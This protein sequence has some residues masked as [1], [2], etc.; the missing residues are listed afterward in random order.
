MGIW[1]CVKSCWPY[2]KTKQE[3]RRRGV[4]QA[5]K[6]W[7]SRGILP[8]ERKTRERQRAKPKRDG[9]LATET[10]CLTLGGRP[11]SD[12]HGLA[13]LTFHLRTLYCSNNHALPYYSQCVSWL[14]RIAFHATQWSPP[15]TMMPKGIRQ[16][17]GVHLSGASW[18][19]CKGSDSMAVWMS[20]SPPFPWAQVSH[21]C[22]D[23]PEFLGSMQ[24]RQPQNSGCYSWA[25][26]RDKRRYLQK[27][28][29]SYCPSLRKLQCSHNMMDCLFSSPGTERVSST[30]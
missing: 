12:S 17:E 30:K 8:A 13:G 1:G 15:T 29:W 24:I 4:C 16:G 6:P 5:E 26:F 14:T 21:A 19:W 3:G 28:S 18:P 27:N 7:V 10:S 20:F 22:K 2:S 11:R 9:K 23:I 25:V